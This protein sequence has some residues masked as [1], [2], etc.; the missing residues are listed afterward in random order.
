MRNRDYFRLAGLSLKS[1][2]KTTIQTVVGISFGLT[3]LFP[4]LFIAIGFYGGINAKLNSEIP[5]RTQR[6]RY[7]TEKTISGEVFCD[8]DYEKDID[9]IGGIKNNLKTDYVYV[10]NKPYINSYYSF[11][12]DGGERI[13][14]LKAND[15]YSTNKYYGIE[16]IDESCANKPFLDADQ[17]VYGDPLVS[18]KVFSKKNSKGEIMVS[19]NFCKDYDL[20]KKGIVGK[21]ISFYGRVVSTKHEYSTSRKDIVRPEE[22]TKSEAITYFK[23]FKIVG[24]YNSN[25]YYRRSPRTELLQFDLSGAYTYSRQYKDYFWITTASLGEDGVAS[26]PEKIVKTN[27]IDTE[28]GKKP[29]SYSAWYYY[30]DKPASLAEKVTDQGWAFLPYGL[31]CFSRAAHIPTYSK[32]QIIEF[33]TFQGARKSYDKIMEYYNKS[34]TGDPGDFVTYRYASDVVAANFTMYQ[35]FFDRFMFV[36]IILAIFGGIIFVAT[37][38]NL[39]N[40]MH[41]SVESNKGFLGICRAEGMKRKGVRRI[42]L[43]QILLVFG[44][45]YI[46]TIIL[47]GAACFFIKYM[48]DN[49]M[50]DMLYEQTKVDINMHWGYIPISLGIL[51]GITII[52]ANIISQVLVRKINK[53]PVLEI[54]S[55]ENRM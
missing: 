28:E 54:L 22:Y 12:I 32:L 27:E 31:G 46:G 20:S 41:F 18:G 42:F 50:Q 14:C 36:C 52:L 8:D 15:S 10:Y 25:I 39:I 44:F 29:I 53:T 4:L 11:S 48:Y 33:H 40:T 13:S 6:I 1:R 26:A 24:V 23:D 2:K 17:I 37:L 34:V 55:E 21:S 43:S 47:G 35:E 19:S 7:S 3:L 49:K 45:A 16:I 30:S 5:C 9:K 51:F 38:L